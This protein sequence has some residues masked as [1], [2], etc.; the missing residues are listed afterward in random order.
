MRDEQPGQGKM[1]GMS[2][3]YQW[4]RAHAVWGR[5]ARA[6]ILGRREEW[7][8]YDPDNE[9]ARIL[10]G[11]ADVETVYEDDHALAFR[12][13][14]PRQGVQAVVL[15]RGDYVG[16]EDFAAQASA[17]E[18]QGFLRA[19]VRAAQTLDLDASGYRLVLD[20]RE[21][22]G[23][24]PHFHAQ[25]VGGPEEAAAASTEQP[26]P[27]GAFVRAAA[28]SEQ[29]L[30]LF[31]L[32]LGREPSELQLRAYCDVMGLEPY[33][34]AR[35][36]GTKIPRVLRKGPPKSLR[37]PARHLDEEGLPV[38]CL[39]THLILKDL[40]PWVV[41]Y[42]EAEDDALFVVGEEGRVPLKLEGR[43]LLVRGKYTWF[44]NPQGVVPRRM[45]MSTGSLPRLKRAEFAHLYVAGNPRPFSFVETEIKDYGFLGEEMSP[46][47]RTNF[48]ALV[49]SLAAQPGVVTHDS[50][51]KDAMQ[52]KAGAE[53]LW[54]GL[55]VPE[56]GC[57]DVSAEALSRLVYYSTF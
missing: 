9:Y 23:R 2:G 14:P 24:V 15:A 4:G 55:Q 39:E 42:L 37:G 21:R 30:T 54:G 38:G 57:P 27:T 31:L 45:G 19:V 7:M 40:N 22:G 47:A 20:G 18:V 26:A 1:I 32:P 43:G 29:E 6:G 11:E 51:L 41:E 8:P 36:L 16:L 44:T 3:V 46:S 52:I 25:L 50:L 5:V 17:D 28:P 48:E 35:Q 56:V 53:A 34:A 33:D 49:A 12:A 10:R 13:P